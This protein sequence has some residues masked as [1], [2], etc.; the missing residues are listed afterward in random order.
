[1][2]T[3]GWALARRAAARGADGVENFGV[4]EIYERDNWVCGICGHP[5][6]QAESW[7]SPR[8][9]SLDHIQPLS[10]GGSHTRDNVRCSHLSCNT[11]RG[12]RI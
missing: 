7:P 11:G 4:A 9:V 3:G 8:S 10:R 5:V 6:D 2:R 1:M 12:N